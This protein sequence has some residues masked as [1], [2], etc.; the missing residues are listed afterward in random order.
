MTDRR[1]HH[2]VR[3]LLIICTFYL[4]LAACA[5]FE[6]RESSGQYVDDSTITA[7]IKQAFITAPKVNS[8]AIHVE[9]MQGVVQLSGFVDSKDA[10][11][12]A[13]DLAENVRG[14]KSVKDDIVIR[15]GNMNNGQ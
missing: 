10:D 7:K 9:T 3:S 13:V 15:S 4:S 6:G 1:Y 2:A 14:V 11:Q 8:A 5:M 12:Q